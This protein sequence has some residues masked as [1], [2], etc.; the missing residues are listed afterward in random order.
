VTDSPS[1]RRNFLT[2]AGVAAGAFA[3]AFGVP[4]GALAGT[5][6]H[7]KHVYK[8]VPSGPNYD[9]SASQEK[10]HNCQA[11]N[12]CQSHAENKLFANKDAAE[13][14]KHRAHP[15]CR[16]GVKRGRRLSRE[17]W[18]DLFRPDSDEKRVVVDKRDPRVRRILQS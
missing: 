15:G 14:E 16:C 9:C 8:L 1:T 2:R 7:R 4:S 17:D 5:P 11:C 12:A 10:N 13:K 3:A 6:G 18:H